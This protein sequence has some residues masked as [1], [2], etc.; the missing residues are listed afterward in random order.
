VPVT[1]AILTESIY[2]TIEGM[3]IHWPLFP[4][5]EPLIVVLLG[6][7][8]WHKWK[9]TAVLQIV[10]ASTFAPDDFQLKFLSCTLAGPTTACDPL[11]CELLL[12]ALRPV[13]NFY[14]HTWYYHQCCCLVIVIH[15]EKPSPKPSPFSRNNSTSMAHC[16]SVLLSLRLQRPSLSST[17]ALYSSRCIT[18]MNLNC[19]RR[20]VLR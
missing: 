19:P 15:I 10:N 16:I 18:L 2:D 13:Q 9:K 20:H 14:P 12:A 1:I 7:C 17:S 3:Q 11:G 6:R 5:L 8:T 4:D